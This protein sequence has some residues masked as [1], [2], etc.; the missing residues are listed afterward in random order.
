MA[1]IAIATFLL[2]SMILMPPPGDDPMTR[3]AAT[4]GVSIHTTITCSEH[5]ARKWPGSGAGLERKDLS[6]RPARMRKTEKK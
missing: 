2:Y 5:A 1:V 3:A 6:F 4:D